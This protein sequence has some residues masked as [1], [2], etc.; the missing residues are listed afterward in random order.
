MKIIRFQTADNTVHYGVPLDDSLGR[1]KLITG[2]LY[3][4]Y[5]LSDEVVDVKRLLAP[6]TGAIV[7]IGCNY[8]RLAQH[9]QVEVPPY[10]VVF[11][12]LPNAINDPGGEVCLPRTLAHEKTKYEGELVV[13]IG[14][15]GVDISP[16]EALA[17]VFG[18]T[19]GND[20]C[21]GEWQGANVGGQWSKGKGFDGYKPIGPAIV[22]VD[23]IPDPNVLHIETRL[24]GQVV[25]DDSTSDM[26]HNVQAC[27]SFASQGHTLRP[28]DMIF[29]G[30]PFGVP[31]CHELAKFLRHGDHVEVTIDPIGTLSN[32]VK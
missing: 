19:V 29:T 4:S 13:V 7:G 5:A 1:A 2:E 11:F 15:K 6:A 22:T 9:L 3:G 23:D 12:S 26:I 14:R 21:T 10:P 24:N 20:V 17:Y 28:G 30:T 18:Y 32:T 25:Q 8:H 31:G 16:D 27:V